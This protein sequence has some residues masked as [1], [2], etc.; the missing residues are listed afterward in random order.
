MP[1]QRGTEVRQRQQVRTTRWTV[2]EAE[3]LSR[4]AQYAGCTEAEILRRLVARA[5]RHIVVSRDLV[6]Q[7]T[8]LGTNINQIAR[9]LNA[10]SVVSAEDLR[11]AYAGLLLALRVARS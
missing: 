3:Q 9:R 2:E 11:D 5:D 10:N 1:G 8:K 4:L 6:L 7:V